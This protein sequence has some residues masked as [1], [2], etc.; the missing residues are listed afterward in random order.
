M[1]LS[2]VGTGTIFGSVW[3]LRVAS[4]CLFYMVVSSPWK[5]ISAQLSWRFKEDPLPTP[6][7]LC[8]FLL[9]GFCPVNS[10]LL[11]YPGT[12][13]PLLTSVTVPS[14]AQ[15]HLIVMQS[16]AS[17]RTAYYGSNRAHP[18]Y[19]LLRNTTLN[20]TI[21]NALKSILLWCPDS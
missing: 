4:L 14:S 3:A 7:S 11:S 13:L 19:Y 1:R 6:H 8:S 2:T 16:P 17:L 18:V 10:S 20:C 12:P 21:S 15:V 5:L 9:S